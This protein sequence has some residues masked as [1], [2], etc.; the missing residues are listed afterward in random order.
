M[1][2]NK[3]KLNIKGVTLVELLITCAVVAIVI[4]AAGGVLLTGIKTFNTN[5]K[6][7][8]SQLNMRPVMI[9]ITKD[10][11][12]YSA[13]TPGASSLTVNG[14]TYTVNSTNETLKQGST[15]IANNVKAI[16]SIFVAGSNDKIILITLTASDNST[17]ST[18]VHLK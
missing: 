14:V 18:Q 4:A 5:M 10:V 11:R 7:T 6:G 2:K 13:A 1:M 8:V 17:L 12:K 15:V 16:S 9:E 3:M